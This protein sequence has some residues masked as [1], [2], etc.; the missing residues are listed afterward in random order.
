MKFMVI[1]QSL[2]VV[3]IYIVEAIGKF[4]IPS[5]LLPRRDISNNIALVTGSGVLSFRSFFCIFLKIQNP[6]TAVKLKVSRF[7][8]KNVCST[9][10]RKNF[11]T[12]IVFIKIISHIIAFID[13]YT[14]S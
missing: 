9:L 2:A 10:E 5:S 12:T 8:I 6:M 1:C 14:L 11:I 13:Y 3:C 4:F 7:C